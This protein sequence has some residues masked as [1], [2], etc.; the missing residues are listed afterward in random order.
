MNSEEEKRRED[1]VRKEYSLPS[2]HVMSPVPSSA[3]G[4]VELDTQHPD[5]QLGSGILLVPSTASLQGLVGPR[6]RL[7]PPSS[8]GQPRTLKCI[9]GGVTVGC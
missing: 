1:R 5:C 6:R 2:H 8:P 7:Q 3:A 9:I 4:L